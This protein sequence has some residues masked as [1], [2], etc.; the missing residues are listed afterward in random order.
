VVGR[1]VLRDGGGPAENGLSGLGQAWQHIKKTP[2]SIASY[3]Q[4]RASFN[5]IK[6]WCLWGGYMRWLHNGET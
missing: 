1:P 5:L 6:N 2:S 4:P 3:F